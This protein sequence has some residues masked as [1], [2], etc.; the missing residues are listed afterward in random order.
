MDT[1]RESI[2]KRSRDLSVVG[3][4]E[5]EAEVEGAKTGF[6]PRLWRWEDLRP[7]MMDIG[8]NV[9][10][11]EATRR[12]LIL[13]NPGSKVIH[14]STN[15]LYVSLS[16]YNPGEI[17]AVHRHTS[18]ASR[19]ILEGASGGYTTIEGE[20]CT[21]E[22]GDLI[23][24]P[25]GTWHDHG[26][27]GKEPA[28][29]VDVLDLPFAE[30]MGASRFEHDYFEPAPGA[31]N[32]QEPVKKTAQTVSLPANYSTDVYGSGGLRPTFLSHERGESTG[33][34]KFVYRWTDTARTL[35]AMREYP[36][37]PYDGIMVEYTNPVN[38]NP[39][40]NT[41]SFRAQLLRPGEKTKAHR[42]TSSTLYCCLEGS[43]TTKVGDHVMEWGPNDLFVVPTLAPHSHANKSNTKDAI[44]YSVTDAPIAERLGLY[45]EEEV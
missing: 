15:S 9:A 25:A 40:T 22:R 33:T 11:H 38:G 17:A 21:M 28:I 4:W 37:S 14:H 8:K 45:R 5:I 19:F 29:W 2:R 23:V 7:L 43:G 10:L 26:N 20:K 27:E 3:L 30:V 42:H 39:V 1:M 44:L 32:S 6:Q 35:R 24:T 41:M 31:S 16:I 13:S 36:G 34:P 18:S 12:V